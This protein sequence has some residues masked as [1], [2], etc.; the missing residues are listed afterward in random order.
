[1]IEKIH[2]YNNDYNNDYNLISV[3]LHLKKIFKHA[4]VPSLVTIF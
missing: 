3:L 4:N 2:D 1:M